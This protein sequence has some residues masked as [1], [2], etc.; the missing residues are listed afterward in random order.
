MH[1]DILI[2]ILSQLDVISGSVLAL[3][4]GFAMLP[5]AIGYMTGAIG[6]L[7]TGNATP[8]SFM[9][10]SM[11]LSYGLSSKFRDRISMIL[12]A[13]LITGV[14]GVFGLPQLIVESVG[15]DIFLAMLAGVGL[16]LARVGLNIAKIETLI[17]IPCFVVA[18]ITQLLT[19]DLLWTVSISIMLGMG[20]HLFRIYVIKI[21]PPSGNI[22]LPEYLSFKDMFRKEMKF[23]KP[24][25]SLNIIIGALALSVLTI[26]GNVAY[27]AFT[28]DI[29]KTKPTYNAGT[30]ISSIADFAS[31]SFGGANM[32]LIISPTA[33]SENAV[34][35]AFLYMSIAAILLA[36]GFVHKAARFLPTSA[37]GGYLFVIGAFLMFPD[38]AKQAFDSGN[39]L[40]VALTITMTSLVN[41]LVGLVTGILTGFL[42]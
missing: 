36:T 8:V 39:T 37:M 12:L 21:K 17:G 24:A 3:H 32:E 40:A 11:V 4:Y 35:A 7:I 30:I 31:S 13:A 16:Y 10:E 38:Y 5:S 22:K 2:A 26:G 28:A 6:T 29:S 23:I 14:L 42:I 20:I 27:T 25:I 34:R 41:P 33:A 15:K 9:Y 18:I 1:R 19:N